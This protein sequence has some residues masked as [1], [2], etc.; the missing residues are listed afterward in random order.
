M[1][2]GLNSTK[3]GTVN[4]IHHY[5]SNILTDGSTPLV[6]YGTTHYPND[7]TKV[8]GLSIDRGSGTPSRHLETKYQVPENCVVVEFLPQRPKLPDL[9][10]G[11]YSTHEFANPVRCFEDPANID[12]SEYPKVR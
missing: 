4:E 12:W 11:S 8:V 7:I 5:T 3:N 2:A 9:P 10:S 1:G 6:P